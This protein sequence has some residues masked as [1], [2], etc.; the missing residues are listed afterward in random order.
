MLCQLSQAKIF[1]IMDLTH[2][3]YQVPLAEH[4]KYLTAFACEFGLFELNV[5]PMGLTNATATFQ[6]LM[7]QVLD[8]LIGTICYV[9]LDDIII[10]SKNINEHYDHVNALMTRL[11]AH[12]L[13][14][15]P[16]KCKIGQTTIQFR[17]T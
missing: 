4:C 5:M 12:N 2:G 15:K 14:V 7:N 6:R 16:T 3:Y 11:K 1:T 9:Y 10:F 8:D 17:V 13:K